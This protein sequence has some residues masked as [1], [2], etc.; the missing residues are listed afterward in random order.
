MDNTEYTHLS[1][2]TISG[3]VK[4]VLGLGNVFVYRCYDKDDILLYVGSTHD[5]SERFRNH[6]VQ[7]P[8]AHLLEYVLWDTYENAAY[9][10]DME[11]AL[12]NK[13]SPPFNRRTKHSSSIDKLEQLLN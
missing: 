7:S 6:A 2:F 9:A 3:W 10:S 8:W 5:L 12:I 1:Q 11:Y 13:L 4:K